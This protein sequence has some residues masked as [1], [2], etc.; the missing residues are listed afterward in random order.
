MFRLSFANNASVTIKV[1]YKVEERAGSLLSCKIETVTKI[2]KES[3]KQY[4]TQEVR[5]SN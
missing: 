4:G 5:A 3:H 1:G 2:C